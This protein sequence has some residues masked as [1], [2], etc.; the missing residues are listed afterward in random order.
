MIKLCKEEGYEV[1]EPSYGTELSVGLDFYIPS[2]NEKFYTDFIKYN[3]K[4]CI[5]KDKIVIKP[6]TGV[7]IPSGWYC[8]FDDN[9]ML[10]VANK[11]G[12]ANKSHLSYA[13]HIID[14]DYQ[15]IILLS[16]YNWGKTTTELKYDNKLVQLIQ[17]PVVKGFKISNTDKESFFTH[18]TKRGKGCLGS[19]GL[20]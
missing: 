14:P 19:T 20:E 15:G 11:S 9:L 6:H 5:K 7:I 3:K 13:A 17:I 4:S 8:K 10:A 12:V 1:K 2:Y 18:K 16:V